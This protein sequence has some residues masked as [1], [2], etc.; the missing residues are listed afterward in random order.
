MRTIVT[1]LA[2][3]ERV[4]RSRELRRERHYDLKKKMWAGEMLEREK[5]MLAAAAAMMTEMAD[6]SS[7]RGCLLPVVDTSGKMKW[8]SVKAAL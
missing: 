5:K 8:T 4:E 6:S 2:Q 1:A 3:S 7:S